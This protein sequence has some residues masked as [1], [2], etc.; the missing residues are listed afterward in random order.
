LVTVACKNSKTMM[1]YIDKTKQTKET[2]TM[3]TPT[4]AVV[5]HKLTRKVTAREMNDSTSTYSTANRINNKSIDSTTSGEKNEREAPIPRKRKIVQGSESNKQQ[6]A[7]TNPVSNKRRGEGQHLAEYE[8]AF[9]CRQ[10]LGFYSVTKWLAIDDAGGNGSTTKLSHCEIVSVCR[11]VGEHGENTDL[12]LTAGTVVTGYYDSEGGSE[13]GATETTATARATTREAIHTVCDLMRVCEMAAARHL[14]GS[15]G[16]SSSSSRITLCFRNTFVRSPSNSASHITHSSSQ[17]TNDWAYDGKWTGRNH[18]GWDGRPTGSVTADRTGRINSCDDAW[19]ERFQGRQLDERLAELRASD[20][21][22]DQIGSQP[23]AFWHGSESTIP[24]HHP[25][26]TDNT[27]V[28]P[29]ESRRE[30]EVDRKKQ[31]RIVSRNILLQG[32]LL[33]SFSWPSLLCC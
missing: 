17:K 16:S 32:K 28:Q 15:S 23:N 21:T 2:T 22:Y 33:Y 18:F 19:Q 10:P 4:F 24:W 8:I 5:M 31:S 11:G 7:L 13:I 27:R 25:E 9:D 3:T 30:R 1:P 14:V 29:V 26:C 6:S 12:R 20:E